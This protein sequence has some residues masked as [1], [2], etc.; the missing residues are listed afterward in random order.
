MHIV[1]MLLLLA[2]AAARPHVPPLPSAFNEKERRRLANALA[3]VPLSCS[4]EILDT[5]AQLYPSCVVAEPLANN[6]SGCVPRVLHQAWR[7]STSPE[8]FAASLN[9]WRSTLGSSWVVLF[10][11]DDSMAEWLREQHPALYAYTYARLKLGIQRSD[12]FRLAVLASYGGVW[13]DLDMELLAS[14]PVLESYLRAMARPLGFVAPGSEWS[15]ISNSLII[16]Q[17][18][19]T[20]W[21]P[22][23]DYCAASIEAMENS[24]WRFI[25]HARVMSSGGP[26]M[27]QAY[28][29]EKRPPAICRLP[30][31]QFSP[32]HYCQAVCTTH[33]DGALTLHHY[34]KGW[35]GW[36]TRL[37]NF[38][39]CNLIALVAFVL[40]ACVAVSIAWCRSVGSRRSHRVVAPI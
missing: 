10:W 33:D 32:C 20:V 26:W 21:E 38:F 16:S 29:E 18:C 25:P 36:S 2:S 3:D 24:L 4:C 30:R 17:H 39:E 11:T 28:L 27:L 9:S 37:H 22:L 5:H 7:T 40:T 13:A 1:V 8:R 15:S 31:A 19:P 35:N 14:L 23:L 34:A 12:V 6:K